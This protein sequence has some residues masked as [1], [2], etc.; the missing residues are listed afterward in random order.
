MSTITTTTPDLLQLVLLKDEPRIDSRLLAQQL[1][2]PHYGVFE[3]VRD[4]QGDFE[5]LGVV[6][7]QTWK[8][9]PGS[10]GGRPERFALL[11]ENQAY[12]LLTYSRN[13]ARVRALKIKLILSFDAARRAAA[14]RQ[15][16]YLPT[17]HALHD[18]IHALAAGSPN[19]RFIHMNVNRLV[20]KAVG[21]KAGQRPLAPLPQQALLVVA[22]HV[23]TQALQQADSHH[24]GYEVAKSAV[25]NLSRALLLG[26]SAA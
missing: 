17:Y 1:R 6:R 21:L 19:E 10:K 20:N 22:Q 16:E 4:Y 26:G 9:L 12:L 15:T 2:R 5:E 13:T 23:A 8:P 14:M 18:R 3:L 11:N 7:F 24:D 25:L